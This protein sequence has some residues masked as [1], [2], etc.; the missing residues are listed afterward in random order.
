MD[1]NRSAYPLD[2]PPGWPRTKSYHRTDA[3][4][5]KR[6]RSTNGFGYL[7]SLTIADGTKRLLDEL[8]K[9]NATT[10]VISSDMK[11]RK[12]GL[13]ISGQPTPPDPGVAVY[14]RDRNRSERC[15]AVDRY[16]S[17]ADNLGAIAATLSAMRAIERHGGAEILDRAF[18]GFVAMLPGPANT[19]WHDI[20][21]VER[22]A[23]AYVVEMRYRVLRGKYHPD[24]P[25]GDADQFLA[26]QHAWDAFKIE[27]GIK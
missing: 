3:L 15:I 20:L 18:T 23:S 10:I 27:R 12:D 8:A 4:F 26:V 9:M 19:P 14:W 24:R 16:N 2:W 22:D 1:T 6:D 11:L 5:G 17:I 7:K 25:E 21:E 13:P